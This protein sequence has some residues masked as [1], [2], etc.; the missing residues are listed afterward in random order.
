MRS[1]SQS[2]SFTGA[3]GTGPKKICLED[4]AR[5]LAPSAGASEDP[6]FEPVPLGIRLWGLV[7]HTA[8]APGDPFVGSISPH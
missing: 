2:R 7:R 1:F 8:G 6:V 4:P 3:P 5:E